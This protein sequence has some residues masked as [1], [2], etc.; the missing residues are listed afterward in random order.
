MHRK[1]ALDGARSLAGVA[2]LVPPCV[3]A[4]VA[5][6]PSRALFA[7]SGASRWR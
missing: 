5:L 4:C 2:L 3:L 6:R 1:W 7:A